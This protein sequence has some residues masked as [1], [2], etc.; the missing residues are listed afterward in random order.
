MSTS[1]VRAEGSWKTT[2]RTGIRPP[3]SSTS[4]SLAGLASTASTRPS[5]LPAASRTTAPTNSCT[6]I[7]SGTS[8]GSASSSTPRNRSADVR[9]TTASNRTMNRSP[10]K[11]FDETT[12]RSPRTDTSTL[13][14]SSRCVWSVHSWTTTS[15]RRPW[16]LVT[17]PILSS[18]VVDDVHAGLDAVLG[19]GHV[20]QGAD[21]LGGAP[22]PADDPPHV[23]RSHVQ[24]QPQAAP[25]LFG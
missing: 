21:G 17:R 11:G 16:A 5:S 4:K 9:S 1:T 18:S 24:A 14:G 20:D 10:P 19:A 23:V 13:P 8:R 12:R 6:H 3:D 7:T 25:T 2:K 22:P 15:P